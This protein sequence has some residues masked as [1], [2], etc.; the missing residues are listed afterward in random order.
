VLAILGGLGAALCWATTTLVASRASRLIDAPSLL[1]SVMTVGLVVA[2]PAAALAGVPSNLDEGSVTWLLVS[3]A[4]NVVGLLFSYSALRIGKV[5]LVGPI[6]STEGAIAAVIAVVAGER[7]APGAGVTLAV[8]ALGVVLAA[9]SP[10]DAGAE[11]RSDSRAALLAV[12]AALSFGF[13]LYA[14]GRVG[15]ELGIAWAALPPRVVGVAALAIP[16]ALMGRWR[17]PRT[18]VPF[19]VVCGL[20]EVLGFWSFALGARHGLAVSAVLASQFA[21]IAAVVAYL[22]FHERLARVQVVGVAA[23]VVGVSVLSALNS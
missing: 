12:G 19:V 18:A 20:G 10:A 13:S 3:G 22:A 23:I 7:L 4:G 9:R 11:R 16:L 21:A 2:A 1:A 17:L 6:A 8:I 15:R 14:T 5:G